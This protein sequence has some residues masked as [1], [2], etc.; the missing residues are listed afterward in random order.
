MMHDQRVAIITVNYRTSDLTIE[1]IKSVALERENSAADIHMYVVDN[2]SPDDS[3]RIVDA[4][5]R[6]AGHDWVTLL[7]AESNGGFAAGNNVVLKSIL[8]SDNKPDYVW[9]LNPDT[10]L[11]KGACAEL[12]NFMSDNDVAIAGSRLEDQDGTPQIS[13]FNFPNI[14]SELCNGAR[15]GFLDSIF[16]RRITRRDLSDQPEKSDWLAGAS[17]MM[18]IE[19]VETVGLMDQSYFLYFEEVDYCLQASHAG[20]ACWYV[21]ASRVYHA[22]GAATRIS[23]S[24]RA[25]PRM[26]AYWFNSRRRF[27]IKNHGA[28]TLVFADI[29]FIVGYSSW[30]L[31]KH[32]FAREELKNEPPYFLRDFIRNSFFYRGFRPGHHEKSVQ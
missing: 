18:K 19:V 24:R 17:V 32:L 30:L 15:L 31:R 8:A 2:D 23:E 29:L 5:L 1:A 7:Q 4:F 3:F 25:K 9:L 13:S 21:P 26:P 11:I 16:K 10:R 14:F 28:L 27:F 22:V 12:I 6:E 20:Y